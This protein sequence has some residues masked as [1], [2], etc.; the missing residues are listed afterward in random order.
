MTGSGCHFPSWTTLNC[1]T[2][3]LTDFGGKA[4]S[5][6][7]L[8]RELQRLEA[9]LQPAHVLVFRAAKALLL[10]TGAFA[11]SSALIMLAWNFLVPAIFGGVTI[12]YFQAFIISLLWGAFNLGVKQL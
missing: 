3:T 11:L 7:E 6:D 4:M 9:R 10:I 5:T 12:S 8:R 1:A 2:R